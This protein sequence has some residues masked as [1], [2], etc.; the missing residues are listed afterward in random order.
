MGQFRIGNGLYQTR[1]MDMFVQVEVLAKV[2]PLLASGFGEIVTFLNV[3][4]SDAVASIGNQELEDKVKS[5]ISTQ[6]VQLLLPISRE[7]AKMSTEDRQFIIGNCLSITERKLDGQETWTP[8]WN[9][10]A[11]MSNQKDIADDVLLT[12]R[13]TLGVIHTV[14]GRFF[15]ESLSKLVERLL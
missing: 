7:L 13:I 6:V 3:M 2:T 12:L 4:R 9:V 8:I 11:R 10:E 15:P 1:P 5:E 14:F